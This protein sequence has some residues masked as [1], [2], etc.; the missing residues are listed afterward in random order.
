MGHG[1]FHLVILECP[2]YFRAVLWVQV[3][4]EI[5]DYSAGGCASAAVHRALPEEPGARAKTE[6]GVTAI[7]YSVGLMYI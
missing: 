3:V 7:E 4:D 6:T 2:H 5:E 1:D